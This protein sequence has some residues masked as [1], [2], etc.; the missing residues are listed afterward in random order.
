[1]TEQ[2]PRPSFAKQLLSDTCGHEAVRG[3]SREHECGLDLRV[4]THLLVAKPETHPSI[5]A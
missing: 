1:M 4:A 3:S 2:P 5:V